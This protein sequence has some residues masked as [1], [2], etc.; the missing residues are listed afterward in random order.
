[1]RKLEALLQLVARDVVP[2]VRCASGLHL[3]RY[4]EDVAQAVVRSVT[5]GLGHTFVVIFPRQSGKNELQA[6]LQAYLLMLF[7]GQ[8]A[9][10]VQVCPTWQP[11]ADNALARPR[12]PA[13]KIR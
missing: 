9:A 5:L 3:R 6:Q 8:R 10:M 7:S 13:R 4:Q 11:Q 1:M 12:D 2:F